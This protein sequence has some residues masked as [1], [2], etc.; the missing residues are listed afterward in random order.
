[1]TR[2]IHAADIHLDSP[3]RGL[4]RYGD[5]PA[6]EI[7]NSTRQAFRNLIDFAIESSVDFVLIAG[8][9]YDG[10]WPD[11]GTGLFFVEQAQ[12]LNNQNIPLYLIAGNHDAENVMTKSLRFPELTF[13]FDSSSAHS[14]EVPG[15]PVVI[16]GQSFS[17]KSVTENLAAN[18]P[19]PTSG[20]FNIGL[21]HTCVS[22]KEGHE[23][24]APCKLEELVQLGY[25][26]WALGHIHVR[27]VLHEN[28]HVVF[29]G[30]LQGRHIRETGAKGCYLIELDES[31]NIKTFEFHELD[32][33]RWER[34]SL[35]LDEIEALED[36]FDTFQASVEQS[37]SSLNNKT[38][39][40]RVE[41]KGRSTLHEEIESDP[42]RIKQE[43]RAITRRFGAQPVWLEK[44]SVHSQPK[45][46][47]DE[48]HEEGGAMEQFAEVCGEYQ[49]DPQTL[50]AQ[51]PELD[52]LKRRLPSE[53]EIHEL[54]ENPQNLQEMIA[55]AEARLQKSL[56]TGE[57][58][59]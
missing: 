21:L 57:W 31:Q 37:L 38:L 10:N 49:T 1:M 54:L 27:E 17:Q 48:L 11:Y 26:Y 47:D 30:N 42:E 3:L 36:L 56:R 7:R 2:F 23:N 32:V 15:S 46:G 8:D 4:E 59:S 20:R 25:D 5:L 40:V 14:I 39:V 51:L 35:D 55:E 41:I 18:Y 24:Y 53:S 52:A 19:R 33:V 22:G 9:L 50:L 28:P 58:A 6:D 43:F 29:S 45:K 44:V 16:H 12:R 13:R 34:L